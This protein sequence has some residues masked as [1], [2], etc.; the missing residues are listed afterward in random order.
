[1]ALPR[2][3]MRGRGRLAGAVQPFEPP[4][5]DTAIY[6]GSASGNEF[7]KNLTATGTYRIYAYL[8]RNAARPNLRV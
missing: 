2:I 6:N 8:K 3:L 7:A 5:A 4:G 1:M